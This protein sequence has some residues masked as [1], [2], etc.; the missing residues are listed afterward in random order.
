MGN[1]HFFHELLLDNYHI[2]PSTTN[3]ILRPHQTTI[4]LPKLLFHQSK[5][6]SRMANPLCARDMP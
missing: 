2:P 4:S 6:L 1:Y 3:F 5:S